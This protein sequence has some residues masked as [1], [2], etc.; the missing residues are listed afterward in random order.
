MVLNFLL[1]NKKSKFTFEYN[2]CDNLSLILITVFHLIIYKV[3][4]FLIKT[5]Y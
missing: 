4:F 5:I 2:S 1:K 3:F